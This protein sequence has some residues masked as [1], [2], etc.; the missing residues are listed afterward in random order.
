MNKK[1]FA[2][3]NSIFVIF[4][5]HFFDGFERQI[6]KFLDDD[7]L[8]FLTF[9]TIFSPFFPLSEPL[10]DGF[11]RQIVKFLDDIFWHFLRFFLHF[12]LFRIHFLTDLS[13][14]LGN[15]LTIFSIFGTFWK[16]KFFFWKKSFFSNKNVKAAYQI[17]FKFS[18]N[19]Q[20]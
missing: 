2:L 14:K 19:F 1:P 18:L 17:V 20:W 16:K 15:F 5:I 11:D 7:F 4:R 9:F 6:G 3:D 12:F 13:D 10:F 8:R